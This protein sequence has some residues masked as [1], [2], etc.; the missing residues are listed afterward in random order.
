MIYRLFWTLALFLLK[1]FFRYRIEGKQHVPKSGGALLVTNHASFMDP[2]VAGCGIWRP[3]TFLARGTLKDNWLYRTLTS[4]LDVVNVKP[5]EGDRGALRAGV[6]A[7]KA[8]K[9]VVMFP[10]GTR[11]RDGRLGELKAGFVLMAKGAGVPI[12][13]AWLSGTFHAWPRDRRL[14]RFFRP[15]GVRYGPPITL[16]EGEPRDVSIARLEEVWTTLAGGAGLRAGDGIGSR[17]PRP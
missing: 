11:T 12:V 1:L 13:P 9:M 16:P 3:I 17:D 7:L 10:E 2:L 4:S 6:E 5:G 8:G 14:P 15:V